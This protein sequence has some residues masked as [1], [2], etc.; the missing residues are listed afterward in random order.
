[1]IKIAM[2]GLPAATILLFVAFKLPPK[3]KDV[4]FK[5]PIWLT[6]TAISWGV[7]HFMVAGVLGP[8]AIMVMDLLLMPGFWLIKNCRAKFAMKRKIK[9]QPKLELHQGGLAA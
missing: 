9:L 2:L 6:A 4:F 8:Y 7:G 3:A 1:M 5:A